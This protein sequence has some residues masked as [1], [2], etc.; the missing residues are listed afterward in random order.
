METYNKH[1]YRPNT[2]LHKWWARRCGSTFRLILKHLVAD[3][4]LQDYYKPGG[5]TGKLI[6]DP[7]MGGATTLHEAIRMGANVIGADLDPIPILQARASLSKVS[8]V[9]LEQAFRQFYQRM[10]RDLEPHYLTTSPVTGTAVPINY[11]L[12]GVQRTC[13][14]GPVIVVDSFILRQ[15]TDGSTLRICSYCHDVVTGDSPCCDQPQ[16]G[17]LVLIERSQKQCPTCTQPYQEDVETP[18]Y[19]RYVP[20]VIVGTVKGRKLFFKA[21]DEADKKTFIGVNQLRDSIGFE[22]EAFAVDRGR[23]SAQLFYRG[24]DNYLDLFSTR[25]LLYLQGAI[26]HLRPFSPAIQLNLGMLVS[27]SLE[28]NSMLCGFKGKN[29]RRAGAIR[30]TFSH[31]A[32]SFPY[33]ALENNPLHHR[34]A[35]G[36]LQKLFQSRIRNGRSWAQRPRERL[37]NQPTVQFKELRGEVD[38]GQEMHAYSDLLEGSRRFYLRQGSSTHL[39]LADHS[40]DFIVTD[41]PYFDSVQYSDLS[42]YFRVWLRHLLPDAAEWDVDMQQSAVDPHKLDRES[43]YRE[44]L[45]GIFAECYRV[46]DKKNGRFIFTFHHWNPKAWAALTAALQHANFR[47]VNRYVVHSENPISVHINKMKSLTH[48]AILVLAPVDAAIERKW[49]RTSTFNTHESEQFCRDC[50]TLVGW[51]LERPLAPS[52][53]DTIWLNAY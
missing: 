12:Y 2:Y 39:P 33:T 1:H 24:V 40:V 19:A 35:S 20:L 50:A 42:A 14:C 30:H 27:T 36:T 25:Q 21:L 16:P 5:L 32:Y 31:H 15:E 23:K 11:T 44:L 47:L 9:D 22:K 45:S 6:L 26:E 41:P 3:E 38:A 52:E 4:T 29:K 53:I 13:T 8:L 51:M 48:D 46:I 18:F 34:K 37:V 17:N 49:E 10:W 28:F 7:M 43:R